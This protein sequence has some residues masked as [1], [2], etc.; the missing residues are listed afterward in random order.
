MH[1]MMLNGKDVINEHVPNAVI[2]LA[3]AAV[4]KRACNLFSEKL[5]RDTRE[6]CSE[7]HSRRESGRTLVSWLGRG[8]KYGSFLVFHSK[9]EYVQ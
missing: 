4:C 1:G 7:Y 3:G 9:Q 6:A 8:G 2:A 5:A